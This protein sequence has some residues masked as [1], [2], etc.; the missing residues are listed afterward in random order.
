MLMHDQLEEKDIG[1]H[2]LKSQTISLQSP[3]KHTS[4]TCVSIKSVG[5][6]STGGLPP[7]SF[8]SSDAG[9]RGLLNY[10]VSCAQTGRAPLTGTFIE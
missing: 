4:D 5:L 6:L 10:G 1:I 3:L 2:S 8:P 9:N 7:T